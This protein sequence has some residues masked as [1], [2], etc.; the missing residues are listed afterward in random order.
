MRFYDRCRSA[1]ATGLQVCFAERAFFS[2]PANH[3]AGTAGIRAY[4]T[5]VTAYVREEN[6]AE[7]GKVLCQWH[8]A[9]MVGTSPMQE[10]NWRA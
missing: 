7:I 2:A 5:A 4:R 3:N 1:A 10:N 8:K 9:V 6:G